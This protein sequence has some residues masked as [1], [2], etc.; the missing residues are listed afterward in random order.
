MRALH[1]LN[2]LFPF[3]DFSEDDLEAG[4]DVRQ[5]GADRDPLQGQQL[6]SRTHDDPD[7]QQPRAPDPLHRRD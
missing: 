4:G 2:I 7:G 1:N 5:R 6:E 3:S